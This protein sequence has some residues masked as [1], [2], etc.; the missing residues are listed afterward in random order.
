MSPGISRTLSIGAI[1]RSRLNPISQAMF[2]IG[3]FVFTVAGATAQSNDPNTLIVGNPPLPFSD[4]PFGITIS[5][6]EV[7][8]PFEITQD[9]P[10]VHD[11]YID[12]V[13][14]IT[15][16]GGTFGTP[17]AGLFSGIG[18]LPSGTYTVRYYKY[19][20][21]YPDGDKGPIFDS[22]AT[23]T[24]LPPGAKA[25][26]V[27][28]Y[29]TQRDHYF[30]TTDANE[31]ALLDAGAFQGWKRTDEGLNVYAA[32]AGGSDPVLAPVCRYYGLPGAGLDT[33]FFS[34]FDFE[35]AA[36]PQL[37]PAQWVL[38]TDNAFDVVLPDGKYAAAVHQLPDDGTCPQGMRQVYRLYNNRADVN[39]RY[40]TSASI[41]DQMVAKGWT[42][43]GLGTN[44]VGFCALP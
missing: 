41:R 17:Y 36:I 37:W 22:S 3:L 25:T 14:R 6:R 4:A 18:P 23:L 16:G 30:M 2:G 15:R 27:E 1:W 19:Y 28:Y 34:A 35:C 21:G 44:A 20:S 32:T 33:H 24:I 12:V 43:E 40:T 9:V 42:P 38:E 11:R 7:G 31:I 10:Y 8:A 26:A 13:L 5:S 39:H 29:N